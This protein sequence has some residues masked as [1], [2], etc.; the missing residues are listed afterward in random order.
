MTY[1]SNSIYRVGIGGEEERF[2]LPCRRPGRYALADWA[3]AAGVCDE[4][5]D[6]VDNCWLKLTVRPA[7]LAAYLQTFG[8]PDEVDALVA[9][10]DLGGGPFIIEAE[11][12]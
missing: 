4:A 6:Y 12:F 5:F 8:A 3:R 10:V 2:P 9:Q 1:I 11:E 7:Q